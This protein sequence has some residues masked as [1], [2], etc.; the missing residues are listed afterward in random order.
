MM[1]HTW[2][3]STQH[4]L[5]HR[6]GAHNTTTTTQA[7]VL[8]MLRRLC[9]PQRRAAAAQTPQ[10]L[11][12]NLRLFSQSPDSTLHTPGDPITELRISVYARPRSA[13]SFH[14]DIMI[15]SMASW[16]EIMCGA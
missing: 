2:A 5:P 13:P 7:K 10:Q 9:S 1:L 14:R 4:E 15:A 3:L 8:A 12:S 16:L 11:V 6:Q